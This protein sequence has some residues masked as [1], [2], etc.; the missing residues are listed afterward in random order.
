MRIILSARKVNESEVTS[1]ANSEWRLLLLRLSIALAISSVYFISPVI[2][3]GVKRS[4]ITEQI[5]QMEILR[6]EHFSAL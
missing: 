6:F 3:V 2:C 4:F 5:L 1:S